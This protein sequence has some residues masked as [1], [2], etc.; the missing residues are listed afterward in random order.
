MPDAVD[1][2]SLPRSAEDGSDLHVVDN[3]DD[4]V[5]ITDGER[6]ASYVR[7]SGEK[8][9]GKNLRILPYG[10]HGGRFS[11]ANVVKITDGARH[12]VFVP[13]K[14]DEVKRRS[15]RLPFGS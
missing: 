7:F 6:T 8:L 12:A 10:I 13:K 3:L 2:A 14:K 11:E 1:Q 5:I 15:S 9:I 4:L